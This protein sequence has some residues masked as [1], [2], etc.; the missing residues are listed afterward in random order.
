MIILIGLSPRLLEAF[1][2]LEECLHFGQ[3]AKRCNVTQSAFSQMIARLEAQVG[4]RLFD[5]DTRSVRLTAEGEV[6]SRRA[7]GIVRDIDSALL[8][9]RDYAV[10]KRGKL[11][12][13]VVPSL[14]MAWV[15]AIVSDYTR[16]YP[17]ISLE[18]F[19]TYS[20]RGLQ[21][22]REGR[23]EIAITGQPGNTGEYEV[24]LLFEEPFLLACP[25][26]HPVAA[27]REL[28]LADMAGLP[29][30]HQIDTERIRVTS[31]PGPYKL[32]PLLRSAR[33]GDSGIEVEH[34]STLAGLVANG[35]G[36]CIVPQTALAQFPDTDV[37]LVPISRKA[38][39]RQIF[40]VMR[41]GQ[42]LSLAAAAFVEML[43]LRARA[44]RP[45]ARRAGGNPARRRPGRAAQ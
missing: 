1:I 2:A 8:E 36:V 42:G 19:D 30:I 25:K 16:R 26:H 15:P 29:M 17:G 43:K 14:A 23:V 18:L 11:A 27:M 10:R 22:L 28:A 12:L 3:A 45:G 32:G 9:M 21:L 4:T 37:A 39:M 40:M 38:F 34:I 20:E 6:F 33:A 13:A 35:M 5:R 24:E 7:R 31:G 41:N 44:F